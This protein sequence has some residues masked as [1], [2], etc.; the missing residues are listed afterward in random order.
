MFNVNK[1]I[2]RMN[3]LYTQTAMGG[4]NKF[5]SLFFIFMLKERN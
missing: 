4:L 1:R 3:T 2:V 5:G